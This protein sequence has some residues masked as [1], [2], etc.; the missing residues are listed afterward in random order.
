MVVDE[1]EQISVL[2]EPRAVPDAVRAALVDRLM[3]R[4]GPERLAGVRG[5]IDVVVDHELER[6]AMH[7]RRKVDLAAGEVEPDDTVALER[8][9]ELGDPQRLLRR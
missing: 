7:L 1:V 2:A 9:A 3:D 8:D 5:A 4:I 6:R